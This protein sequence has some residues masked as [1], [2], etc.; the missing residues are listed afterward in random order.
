M[1]AHVLDTLAAM[2]TEGLLPAGLGLLGVYL[3]CFTR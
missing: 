2:T 3:L 1:R